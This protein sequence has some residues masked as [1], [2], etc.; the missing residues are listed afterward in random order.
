VGALRVMTTNALLQ[1]AER[2]H[3]R[4]PTHE[5][6]F[7]NTGLPGITTTRP[8]NE[9]AEG[10]PEIR[11][12]G[13]TRPL[14]VPFRGLNPRRNRATYKEERVMSIIHWIGIDDHAD[15]WTIAHFK[16]GERRPAKEFELVPDEKGYRHLLSFLKGLRDEVRVVYEAGPCGY[17]LSRRLTKAGYH[18]QVAAPA[19]TPRKPGERVKTNRR[20]A[21]KLGRY[22]RSDDL[23]FVVVPDEDRESLRDL[24]RSRES[25]QKDVGR[26]RKQIVHL[27]LRYGQRYREGQA[28]TLRFWA[29]LKKVELPSEYS[30]FVLEEMI[31]ELVHRIEQ[32]GRYDEQVELA[33][34]KPEYQPYLAAL[35]TLRGISTLSAI[36]ILSELGD[37]R[38][39]GR[40]PQMMAA[41]GVV[42]SEYSTGDKTKRFAI[43]KT[44]NAHVRRIAVEAA[45]HYQ[46]RLSLGRTVQARR[47]GQP[48]EIVAIAEKCEKRLNARFHRLTSRNKKS[49]VAVVAV[50][51]ELL[52]FVWAIGQIAHP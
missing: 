45:W 11:E 19:L 48:K 38:R 7:P 39:F 22:L 44:G 37:L 34:Q 23:T 47:K 43:T 25:V 32:L 24:I 29:W 15:K 33:A 20:D 27:L 41:V 8:H 35:R 2:R 6:L 3:F 42:P 5:G 28:W 4:S 36:T 18:C 40:A 1:A 10:V 52:G 9:H 49:T 12:D 17:E 50:A 31:G 16:G 30:R 26:V 21:A 13:V 14:D 51:R 46:R